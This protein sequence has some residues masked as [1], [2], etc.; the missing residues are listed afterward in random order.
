MPPCD[1]LNDYAIWKGLWYCKPAA[2]LLNDYGV[3]RMPS[4]IP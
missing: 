3:F 4:V 1:A 2:D